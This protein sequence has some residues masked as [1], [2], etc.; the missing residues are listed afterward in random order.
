MT[1][2]KLE[3]I[4]NYLDE[5]LPNVGTELHY[6]K[7]YELLFAVI[8]SAQT[9][10]VAVN[11]VTNVLFSKFKTLEELSEAPI[12]EIENIIKS[13]GLFRNKAKNI[14]ESAKI[15]LLKFNGVIPSKKE[16]LLT[17]PGVGVKTANVVR[18]ELFKIPEIAVDTHVFR[19]AKRLGFAQLSAKI[20]DVEQLLRKKIP[21]ERYIL[22]H[23]QF[24]HFGRY[25]CQARNPKCKDCKLI[26]LCKEP[27]KNI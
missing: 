20:E 3:L 7:D 11:K 9:T 26:S 17:L 21:V 16:D 18:A 24:I 19:V 5:I 25:V 4:F 13:I 1:K 27:K 2:N 15:L 14:K 10:D 6:S 12:E 8:L 22:T 23:H